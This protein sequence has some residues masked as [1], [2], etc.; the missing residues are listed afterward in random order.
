LEKPEGKITLGR[1]RRRRVDNIRTV[2][3][4]EGVYSF[5][6]GKPVSKRP[7]GRPRRRWVDKIR[8]DLRGESVV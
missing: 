8:M 2:P 4:E 3:L 7:L 5:L 6:V 1:A